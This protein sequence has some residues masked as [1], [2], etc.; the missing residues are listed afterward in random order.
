MQVIRV[1]EQ[2]KIEKKRIMTMN[3]YL[4]RKKSNS[5][6]DSDSKENEDKKKNTEDT[7]HN[8]ETRT[9]KAATKKS[10]CKQTLN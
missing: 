7:N 3:F 10:T 8:E 9:R 1:P 5:K 4:S 6:D 2:T